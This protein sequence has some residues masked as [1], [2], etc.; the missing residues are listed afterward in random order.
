[1]LPDELIPE[2][3]QPL[4]ELLEGEDPSIDFSGP[5]RLVTVGDQ[6]TVNILRQGFIPDIA[7]VDYKVK[8]QRMERSHDL[9]KFRL[10]LYLKNPAGTIAREAWP[11]LR[12][13]FRSNE[14]IRIDVEGEEDLLALPSIALAPD[15]TTVT[16]GL[17]HRGLVVVTANHE[18]KLKVLDI[19][20]RM[21]IKGGD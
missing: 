8:R 17:P 4:G 16:Y 21:V 13:A 18:V 11:V 7:I 3:R 5:Q 2:V 12:N 6:C 14:S 9:D 19:M 1:L 10:V 15:D 20:R